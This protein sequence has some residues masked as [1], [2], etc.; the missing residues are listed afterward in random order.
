MQRAGYT[1]PA[2]ATAAVCG[3]SLQQLQMLSKRNLVTRCGDVANLSSVH[4]RCNISKSLAMAIASDLQFPITQYM[5]S[6]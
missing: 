5:I 6:E 3:D 2:D 1:A 4:F